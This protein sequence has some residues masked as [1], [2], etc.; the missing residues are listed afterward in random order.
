MQ[1]NLTL[2]QENNSGADRPLY[3]GRLIRAIVI[4]SLEQLKVASCKISIF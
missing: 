1:E 2:L 3:L 4:H